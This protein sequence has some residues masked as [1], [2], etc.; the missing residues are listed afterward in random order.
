MSRPRRPEG[1]DEWGFVVFMTGC[2]LGG[3]I[4]CWWCLS[5]LMYQWAVPWWIYLPVTFAWWAL[6]F[7]WGILSACLM[8][9]CLRGEWVGVWSIVREAAGELRT[10]LRQ[11]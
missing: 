4:W 9:W 8:V 1:R 2:A 5:E 10:W 11:R 6:S 3:A 7:L